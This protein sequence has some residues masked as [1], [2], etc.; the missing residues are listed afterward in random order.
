VSHITQIAEVFAEYASDIFF[1]KRDWK[2]CVI[3]YGN[4]MSDDIFAAL[5]AAAL[6][7]GD[8][9]IEVYDLLGYSENAFLGSI[10]CS[11]DAF[12]ELLQTDS[13]MRCTTLGLRGKSGSW[14]GYL[15]ASDFGFLGGDDVAISAFLNS[16]KNKDE[17]KAMSAEF[18]AEHSA[19]F[20]EK[21]LQMFRSRT[22]EA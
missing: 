9:S 16:L 19:V 21:V 20:N 4:M 17:F 11:D 14:G 22:A 12:W 10:A 8:Q 3:P 6:A 7:H 2:H 1:T 15:A 13:F 5:C 18:V